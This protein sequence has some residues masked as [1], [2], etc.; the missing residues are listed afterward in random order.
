MVPFVIAH[1]GDS[2]HRP[3]NT[4]AAF[5]SALELGTEVMELDVQLTRDG[6][7][8]VIHDPTLDRTTS[9]RGSVR[10]QTLAEI[11]AVSAGYPAR[12]GDAYKGERVPTL[13]EALAF[14]RD[15]CR[16]MIELK[17]D[18]VTEDA[19]GGLEALTIEEIRKARMEKDSALISFS[20]L[21]LLRCRRAAP[22]I[23]RG[24]L[25]HDATPDE[26]VA[27]AREAGTDLV[28]PEKSMLTEALFER[29]RAAG[30]RVAT[31]V[32]DEP[33]ELAAL[34]GFELYGFASNR[35]GVLMDAVRDNA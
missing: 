33:E 17:S 31:W 4:L 30:L 21:A 13:A 18:S 26:V 28:M 12:F 15:R 2:A 14:L 10:E 22:E 9:G 6:H 24:H 29:A 32:L 34:S 11:R 19:D 27:G 8:I 35:P 5:A 7:V 1:R 20:R 16:P 25:F 23:L 3:E